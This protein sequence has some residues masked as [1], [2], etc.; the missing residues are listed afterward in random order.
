MTLP[1]SYSWI[2]TTGGAQAVG[3]GRATSGARISG[4]GKNGLAIPFSSDGR[5]RLALVSGE[6]Q[7][8]KI[9]VL[10]LSDLD[11]SNPFQGELGIGRDMIFAIASE[12]L[13]TDL[14]RRI[15]ELFRRLQLQDRARLAKSPSFTT[16]SNL[17]E[18]TVNI[19]YINLEEDKPGE[20]GLTFSLV[21]S[22]ALVGVG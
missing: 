11:S 4:D 18:L 15:K 1:T 2:L 3:A 22:V 19:A 12:S 10:N 7:L 6:A 5:G 17:Q 16:D 21:N 9:I 8:Q 13:R 14:K 20:V